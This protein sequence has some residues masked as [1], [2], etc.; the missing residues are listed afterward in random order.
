[1]QGGLALLA[2]LVGSLAYS[3]K[4]SLCGLAAIPFMSA[5]AVI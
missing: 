2:G 4:V 3:W 1:M 5:G